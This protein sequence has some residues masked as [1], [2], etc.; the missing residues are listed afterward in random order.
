MEIKCE[1]IRLAGKHQP[2]HTSKQPIDK[3]IQCEQS[4]GLEQGDCKDG[5]QREKAFH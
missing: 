5:L 1:Q 4:V 3:L 2:L